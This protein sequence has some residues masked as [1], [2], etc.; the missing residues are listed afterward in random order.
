MSF[1]LAATL[2]QLVPHP[3]VMFEAS[4]FRWRVC[5]A[6]VTAFFVLGVPVLYTLYESPRWLAHQGPHKDVMQALEYTARVNGTDVPL[7]SS[8]R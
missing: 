8:D 6:V 1:A 7:Q 5:I 4:V 2:L 3:V